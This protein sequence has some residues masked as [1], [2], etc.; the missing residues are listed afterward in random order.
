MD[1][2][3]KATTLPPTLP[4]TKKKA[5]CAHFDAVEAVE[6]NIDSAL[7]EAE[8]RIAM[9]TLGSAEIIEFLRIELGR[10]DPRGAHHPAPGMENFKEPL[11][12]LL[13]FVEEN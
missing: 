9:G 8:H 13:S 10:R 5:E 12:R 1:T 4:S 7:A 6:L 3:T 2:D 11:D